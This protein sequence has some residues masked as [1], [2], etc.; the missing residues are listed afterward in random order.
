MNCRVFCVLAIVAAFVPAACRR[1]RSADSAISTAGPALTF[2][3]DIAPILFEYCATC[4]RPVDPEDNATAG[5]DPKC[6]AGA[7]FPL[8]EYRDVRA[9]AQQIAEATLKRVMPPWLP[10][11][12][13]DAFADER[14]LSDNQIAMIQQWVEGGSVEGQAADRP[15]IPKWPEGWQLGQPDLVLSLATPYALQAAGS[16]VF[17]NFVLPVPAATTRYVR[18]IEFRAGNPRSLHHASVGVDRFRVSRKIDRSDPGPGFAAMPDD[19]VEN[20]YGWSPGKVPFMEPADRA[21][22]LEKGSDLVIQLHM[23]PTGAP[24]VVQPTVGLFFSDTPPTHAPLTIRLESK[25]ID[26]P[27]GQADYAIDD[28]YRLP[29]DV[30]LLSIYPHAHYLAKEMKGVAHLPDGSVKRL[31]TINAWDFRWQDQYRYKTPVFL[32]K[33]TTLTMHFTYDN[34]DRNARNPQHPPQ[35]VKWGPQSTNEMGALWLE[36]LPRQDADVAGL[37]RD[38]TERSLRAD[39]AGA[40]MQVAASPG[41]ALAHNFLATKYLQAGRVQDATVHLEQALRLKPD[42]AEAHSNLASALQLQGRLPD[43]VQHAREAARL[44]P[45]DDR[46]RFNLGNA[47]SATGNIDEAIREF[48]RAV[49]LN[50]ENAD[51]HFNLAML[52]GPRNRIDEAIT[53]L[54]QALA[55]DPRNADAHRNLAVALGFKGRIVEGIAEARE[56]LRLQPDSAEARRQLNLLLKARQK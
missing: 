9:H 44:K 20:V 16:D 45:D 18:G 37:M 50:P 52:L 49:Q 8:L 40:E 7:P 42:D 39:I 51:A 48:G 11:P 21:W 54:R 56:A 14:R 1:A 22:S 13:E 36:I 27:A 12:R 28:S 5:G 34:S 6:F 19:R 3:K 47:M 17:R 10:E 15:A 41:D 43:A 26:I 53:H 38:Y 25:A 2:N 32:P 4:H 29:A 55:I 46:V 23:L 30:D 24:E 33:G 31:I 35:R